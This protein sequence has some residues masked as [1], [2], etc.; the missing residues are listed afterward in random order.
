MTRPWTT[1]AT[2]ATA[3]GPLELRQRGADQFL[4]VIAGRILMTSTARRSEEAL[5]RLALDELGRP[6][7]R[8]LI[9]GLGMAFTLRAALDHLPPGA[10]VVVAE[11]TPAVADWCRGPLAALTAHALD[12]RRVRLELGDV[13]VVVRR[14]P[15]RYDAII[16]DLYEGP[17]Q[18]G[19]KVDPVFGPDGLAAA[20]RALVDDGV[21]AVWGEDHDPRFAGRLEA[22]GFAARVVR[23]DGGGR[24]HVI[25]LG[26]KRRPAVSRRR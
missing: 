24:Q 3:E 20:H 16:Y 11:L 21:F 2:V 19:G 7:G 12:D 9:G 22:A 25:Y 10:S 26:R 4:I 18:R 15:G 14:P 6:A 23:Q 1:L 8:V 13:G 5:S 17:Y